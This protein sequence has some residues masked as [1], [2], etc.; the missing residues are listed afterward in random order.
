MQ[1]ELLKKF[2]DTRFRIFS[3]ELDIMKIQMENHKIEDMRNPLKIAPLKRD[4]EVIPQFQPLQDYIAMEAF[5]EGT[6]ERII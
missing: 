4:Q 3:T 1:I 6:E 5:L 2:D